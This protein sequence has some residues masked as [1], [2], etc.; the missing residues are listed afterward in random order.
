[1]AN[2]RSEYINYYIDEGRKIFPCKVNEKKP[3]IA[4]GFK[5][6]SSDPDQIKTWWE[7]H[8]D[9]NIGLVTGKDAN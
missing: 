2:N 5:N 7:N 1:M 4:G 6:A 8:P 9:A 3:I